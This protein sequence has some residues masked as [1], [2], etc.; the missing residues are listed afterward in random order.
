MQT[1]EYLHI[2]PYDD[3][4]ITHEGSAYSSLEALLNHLSESG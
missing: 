4:R 2:T 3:D 1:W